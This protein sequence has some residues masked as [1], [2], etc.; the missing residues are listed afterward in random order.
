[1]AIMLGVAAV[2]FGGIF[3]FQAFKSTMMRRGMASQ[4]MPPQTVSAIKA[5]TL[6]WQP[7]LHAVGTLRATRGTDVSAEVAGI[8]EEIKFDSGDDVPAGRVLVNLRAGVD[9]ARLREAQATVELARAD[10]RRNQ[11]LAKAKL[12][13][14]ATLDSSTAQL[15]SA[16]AQ[17]NQ[18]FEGV[19]RTAVHAPFSGRIGL[20]LVDVGQYLNAGTKIATLQALDELLVDFFLPQREVGQLTAGQRVTLST[21]AYPGETFAGQVTAIDPKV[22]PQTRNVAV[23]SRIGN[24]GHKLLPG[25]YVAV[26]IDAGTPQRYITLPQTAV[27][28]NSYGDTV[29]V[30]ED[31]G[32][33]AGPGGA[34]PVARQA[35][36]TVGSARGDQIAILSGL[37][38]GVTVVTA[39]QIKLHNGTPVKISNA[40]QPSNDPAPKPPD[41]PGKAQ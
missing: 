25:M 13:S 34:L 41:E 24:A 38:E 29:F 2:L 14:Q 37:Q 17:V 1:M 30:V 11:E 28:Y 36:V 39:G 3:G 8:V 10:F 12:V 32:K 7:R 6:E 33:A 16:E 19:K 20:R 9:S 26:E 5:E 15:R 23:R 4:G 21:D 40:V 18:Q 35:F 31:S 27:V 22:D